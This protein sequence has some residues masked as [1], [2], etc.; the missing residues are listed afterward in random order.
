MVRLQKFLADAGVASRRVGEQVILE[1]RVAVNGHVVRLLGTKVNPDHDHVAVDG[2]IVRTKKLIYVALNKPAGCVCSRKDELNRPTIYALLPREWETV[3]SVGRLD[4][5][6][7]G[8]IFLTND[9]QFALRLTHP[10]YGVR[11]KY[12]AHV[13]GEVTPAM[14]ALFKRGIFHEGERLKALAARIVSGTR[15]KSV[16]EL[17]LGEGKNREVRRLFE[18]QAVTV[19]KLQRTQRTTTR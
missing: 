3:Q 7:E 17:E 9:G 14:L 6:S 11:K 10:R 16:V 1:G 2:K 12:L 18:S 15:H 5:N 13:E 4:Y 8:L 19:T